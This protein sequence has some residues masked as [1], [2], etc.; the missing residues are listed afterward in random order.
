[1]ELFEY[2]N[3]D[4]KDKLEY[5]LS[6]LLKTNRTPE[7]FINWEK[8]EENVK[9]FEV[10]LNIMNYLIGKNNIYYEARILFNKYPEVIKAIPTLLAVRE[11]KIDILIVDENKKEIT[12]LD[13]KKID[14]ENIEKYLEF[15]YKTGLLNF[16]EKNIKNSLV[17][18]VYGIETG[19]D[20]N[21]RKNRSGTIME[22]II[23]KEILKICKELNLESKS[24][25]TVKYIYENWGIKVPVDKSERKFDEAVFDKKN[26]KLW[27]IE[28]NFYGS[29][30][31]KLKA[32][33]GEFTEL[34][35]FVSHK[36]NVNFI[37]VTDGLGWETTHLPLMEAMGKVPYIFNIKMLE[38]GYLYELF[39]NNRI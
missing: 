31:S 14:K 39:S 13:F 22:S 38:S 21:G 30:G 27:L 35:S 2:L 34:N 7:Y 15:A 32:V 19:I 25:A 6:T 8:V 10:E 24:Q 12:T 37:W 3:L 9:E 4:V 33:A 16:L 29:N 18:F 1:M 11:R 28:T 36:E 23:E 26:N 17:D 5:F 20:T